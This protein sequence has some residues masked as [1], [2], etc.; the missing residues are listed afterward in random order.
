MIGAI[1]CVYLLGYKLSVAVWVGI[2]ALA[3]KPLISGATRD[4]CGL[5]KISMRR[6]LRRGEA[7]PAENDDR[8]GDPG[9]FAAIMWSHG[10]GADVMKR[11]AAPMIGGVVSSF[12][13]ELP[14]L[15]GHLRDLEGACTVE[16]GRESGADLRGLTRSL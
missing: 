16:V 6:L 12:L 4:A 5:S 13:L 9:R 15:S 3:G 1:W 10:A 2:I 7:H 8:H 14:G 11:I